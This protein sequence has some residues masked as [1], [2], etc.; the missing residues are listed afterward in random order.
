MNPN[1]Q[2]A[3]PTVR[4]ES[5]N[6]LATGQTLLMPPPQESPIRVSLPLQM[7]PPGAQIIQVQSHPHGQPVQLVQRIAGDDLFEE[8][9]SGHSFL[10]LQSRSRLFQ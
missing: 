6:R 4:L 3:P 10:S 2:S 9:L 1:L 5:P 8:I 7:M